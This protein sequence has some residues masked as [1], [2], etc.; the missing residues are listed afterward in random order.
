MVLSAAQAL[1][2]SSL[3]PRD[4]WSRRHRREVPVPIQLVGPADAAVRP[5]VQVFAVEVVLCLVSKATTD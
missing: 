5:A 1:A 2:C 4:L 3:S